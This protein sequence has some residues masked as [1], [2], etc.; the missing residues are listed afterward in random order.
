MWAGHVAW[1]VD[2]QMIK[3]ESLECGLDGCDALR[4]NSELDNLNQIVTCNMD[5]D[6]NVDECS[7]E[8]IEYLSFNVMK[9]VWRAGEMPSWA[10]FEIGDV[11]FECQSVE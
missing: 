6:G 1:R 5:S 7:R 3:F 11:P 8:S 4:W 9:W 2:V 10:Y